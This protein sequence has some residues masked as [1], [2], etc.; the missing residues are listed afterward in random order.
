MAF[1]VFE[2]G[3]RVGS[4]VLED[5]LGEGGFGR[6]FKANG[7]KGPVAIKQ[8]LRTGMVDQSGRPVESSADLSQRL[9]KEAALVKHVQGPHVARLL[10]VFDHQGTT[11]MVTE[12]VPTETSLAELVKRGKTKEPAV[13]RKIA[14]GLLDGLR[15]IHEKGV[16]HKD[17]HPRN[18]LVEK[19]TGS[20]KIVDFG[21]AQGLEQLGFSSL[22][23]DLG[24][25]VTAF[26]APELDRL[27]QTDR[28]KPTPASDIYSAGRIL[29][30]LG[31]G[32][33]RGCDE[34][35]ESLGIPDELKTGAETAFEV[36]GS[37]LPTE[38]L[39]AIDAMCSPDPAQRASVGVIQ[40][41]IRAARRPTAC[42]GNCDID[43]VLEKMAQGLLGGPERVIDSVAYWK[44][45][46]G[47]D[48]EF[49]KRYPSCSRFVG[50]AGRMIWGNRSPMGY[51]PRGRVAAFARV[52]A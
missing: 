31:T 37:H 24:G 36:L 5:T 33:Y 16:V 32:T 26:I 21:I 44:N 2:P 39:G 7:P 8:L 42:W 15:S 30:F 22:R 43:P 51:L 29:H 14:D 48:P 20:V 17:L 3:D 35:S 50:A 34:L 23:P 25:G 4:Y 11:L 9:R 13:W 10:E 47:S 41:A 45:T 12:Y 27:D 38:Y 19:G 40:D 28:P 1:V 52:V 6:T 49:Q 46:V 18:V